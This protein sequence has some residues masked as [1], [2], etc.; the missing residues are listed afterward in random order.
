MRLLCL[1]FLVLYQSFLFAETPADWKTVFQEEFNQGW[2]VRWEIQGDLGDQDKGELRTADGEVIA[3]I[4]SSFDAEAVRVQCETRMLGKTICDLSFLIGT[5]LTK[6][7]HY[8]GF[9]FAGEFN[10]LSRIVSQGQEDLANPKDIAEEGKTHKVV[11]ELN[12]PS[13]DDDRRWQNPP[14]QIAQEAD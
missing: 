6:A 7:D 2:Q 12:G 10:T 1:L 14:P 8:C 13:R 5:D 11:A 4:K 9:M 3:S